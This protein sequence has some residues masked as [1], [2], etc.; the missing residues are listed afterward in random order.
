M[1]IDLGK[2]IAGATKGISDF[3][4]KTSKDITKAIDQNGDGKLDLSDIQV[5]SD[6]I[7]AE[8]AEN[9][10]KVD[11]ERLKPLFLD[12]FERAEFVMPKLIRVDEIDKPHAESAICK[13]SIGFKTVQGDL[14]ALTLLR[15]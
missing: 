10:R 7:Q 12:D 13:D 3:I 14:S 8:R 5:I 4:D 15:F 2:M 6:K 9:Q 11:L 1:G